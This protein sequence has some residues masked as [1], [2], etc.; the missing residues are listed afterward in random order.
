MKL[1]II[2]IN[3]NNLQGL[4][5]TMSSV[6]SQSFKDFEYII[7]DGDSSD[8]S[9][10]QIKTIA[11]NDSRITWLSEKDSGVFNAMNKGITFSRGDYLLFLNSGDFLVDAN[12]IERVFSREANCD[13]IIGQ[14]QYTKNGNIIYLFKP[15]SNYSLDFFYRGSISHQATFIHRDLFDRFGGY[16]E[17]Y[18]LMGDWGFFVKSIVLGGCSILPLDFII[19][20]YNLDGIS[21]DP[22]N[23]DLIAEEK[24]RAY[25]S[26]HLNNIICDYTQW[27][28]WKQQHEALL[29]AWSKKIFRKPL[30]AIFRFATW[31]NTLKK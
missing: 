2:T 5:L 26:L 22:E 6:L 19:S 10:E 24:S 23:K 18:K 1:S 4:R 16:P 14:C 9:V 29:W 30:E 21:S 17:D 25:S 3:L 13:L 28:N 7:I 20:D 27:D 15:S 8:G 11:A 31:I 12:V